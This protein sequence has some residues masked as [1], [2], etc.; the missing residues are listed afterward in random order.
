MANKKYYVTKED[1]IKEIVKSKQ[2]QSEHPDW[3]PAQC[4][5]PKL[6]EYIILLVER[7]STN[8]NWR[9]YS[10]LED[11]KSEALLTLCQNAF[12]YD[13]NRY[14]NPFGY[15]TQIE[16]FCFITY[17]EKED[18]QRDIKDNIWESIEMS[19]SGSRQVKNE[20]LNHSRDARIDRVAKK[21]KSHPNWEPPGGLQTYLSP[22][23]KTHKKEIEILTE[24]IDKLSK[25]SSL[26]SKMENPDDNI[27]TEISELLQVELKPYTSDLDSITKL[28]GNSTYEI[29]TDVVIANEKVNIISLVNKDIKANIK[30][31][32]KDVNNQNIILT[33]A[34]LALII[35]RDLSVR[36]LREITG[37]NLSANR[38]PEQQK[39]IHDIDNTTI[40]DNIIEDARPIRKKI[41]VKSNGTI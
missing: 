33:L 38:M 15:Y 17:K 27:D 37:Y 26:I 34:T 19:P 32:I 35:H 12:K 36:E 40:D 1:L 39:N 29:L 4:F 5:T 23:I 31:V 22:D 6:T 21:R 30:R 3:T 20:T 16:K 13:E 9:N 11:M 41:K 7:Y 2:I 14:E 18:R 8:G 28:L 25:L 10:W 24:K